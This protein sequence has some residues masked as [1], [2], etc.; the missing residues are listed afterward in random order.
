MARSF[1]EKEGAGRN[2]TKKKHKRQRH[3]HATGKTEDRV[4][5]KKE[6]RQTDF[7]QT[8]LFAYRGREERARK[9]F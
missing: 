7:R 8:F 9:A 1:E 4:P 3:F 5:L 6:G 2:E